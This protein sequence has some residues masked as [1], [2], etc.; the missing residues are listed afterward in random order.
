VDGR[1]LTSRSPEGTLCYDLIAIGSGPAGQGAAVQAAKLGKRAAIVERQSVLGGTSTN[2]GTIPSKTLRA[3]IVEFSGRL[4][5][6]YRRST[7]AKIELT[8]DDLLWRTQQ[9]I[10]QEQVAI[11]D[12]LRRNRV[13][14]LN[15]TASFVDAHT[16]EIISPEGCRRAAAQWFV[17]AVG[18][19][20][21]RPPVVHF[22]DRVVLDSD[23]ILGLTSIPQT[24]TV[25]G[26]NPV[27]LEYASMAAALGVQVTLV[28]RRKHLLGFADVEIVEALSYYLAGIGVVFRLGHDVAAV[29]RSGEGVTTCLRTGERILSDLLVYAAS[30]HGATDE[31]D[32]GAAGLQADP[33]G[34]LAVDAD[35]RTAQ[36]HI[37]AAGDVTGFPGLA[38]TSMEQGRL[39]ALAA[40]GEPVNS[41]PALL[42]YGMYTIP[43]I[44]FL[45][46]QESELTEAE[47]PYVRGVARYRELACGEIAGDRTGLLKL[48]VH[49]ET[50]EV[51]GVHILGTSATELIHVGQTVMA[52]GLPVDY[53]AKAVFN[54]PSFAGAYK[55]A[56]LDAANRLKEVGAA[57]NSAGD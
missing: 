55:V 8:V 3:A 31:L 25:V 5:G 17:I 24:L 21:S 33:S 36:H 7:R 40:F 23:G 28:D 46:A 44:S 11:Q 6:T 13:D 54:V 16:I 35:L 27:G 29:E 34:R 49:A 45:G 37:F 18:T 57:P 48:L 10:E 51:L 2:S 20:P 1:A 4:Q 53:L 47:V 9:V 14:V 30:R 32:L 39:A 42:P 12:A 43:E 26:A 15:G 50:R 38:A 52:S 56:A 19:K 22:D 41:N